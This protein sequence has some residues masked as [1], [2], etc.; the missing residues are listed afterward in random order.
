MVE[1]EMG[2]AVSAVPSSSGVKIRAKSEEGGDRAKRVKKETLLEVLEQCRAALELLKN[3]ESVEDGQVL[4]SPVVREDEEDDR[5]RGLASSGDE[6]ESDELQQLLKSRVESPNFLEKLG[7]VDISRSQDI[8]DECANWDLI[9]AKDLW[10]D[11]QV[12]I[13]HGVLKQD[14]GDGDFVF[15]KQED[16]VDGI[17]CFMA[18]YLLSLK[19]TKELT[20]R[21]IQE[22]LSKTFSL[23][24]KK[25]R[26][27]KAWD[28]G[29]V[30]YNVAS[31]GAT[32]VGIYQNPALLR[33]ASVAFW[34][35][36]QTISKFF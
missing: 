11:K 34:T 29:R 14:D 16:I 4:D 8:S 13:Q 3:S 5:C 35:S 12:D 32:A 21:Q 20:P 2:T 23:K 31:W 19:E 25:G 26:L 7:R 33:A 18:T 15:V 6:S 22:A 17:A 24:K 30:I 36:C 9:T 27:R 10:E 1:S 28:G